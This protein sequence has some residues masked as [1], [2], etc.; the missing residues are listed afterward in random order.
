MLTNPRDAFAG[1]YRSADSSIPYV[2]HNFLLWNSNFV[3]KTV[4]FQKCRDL[5]I[6]VGGRSRSLKAVP[7]YAPGMVSY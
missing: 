4:D 6:G 3:F 2:T 1:Q 7:F 5:E